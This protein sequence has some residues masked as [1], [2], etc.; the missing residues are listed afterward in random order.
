M[1]YRN[2]DGGKSRTLYNKMNKFKVGDR[3]KILEGCSGTRA[4]EVRNLYRSKEDG[5]LY[6]E[7]GESISSGCSCE[8]KW[9]WVSSGR[10]QIPPKFILIYEIDE[11]PVEK[12]PTLTAVRKRIKELE[13]QGAHSYEVYEIKKALTVN[14]TKRVEIK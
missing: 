10:K 8:Y 14:I 2:K 3:V 6:A 13:E 5:D 11:D 12:F 7:G 4:G 1:G 9:E